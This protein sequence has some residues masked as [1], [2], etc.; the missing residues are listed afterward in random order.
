MTLGPSKISWTRIGVGTVC[1]HIVQQQT[2]LTLFRYISRIVTQIHTFSPSNV[3]LRL[4]DIKVVV[5]KPSYLV[6]SLIFMISQHS[7]NFTL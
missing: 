2:E 5:M 4:I 3:P 7:F 1:S 6:H